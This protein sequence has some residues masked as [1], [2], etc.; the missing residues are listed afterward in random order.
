M[1]KTTMERYEAIKKKLRLAEHD[2]AWHV[3]SGYIPKESVLRRWRRLD[4]LE[5]ALFAKG[6][7]EIS[8]ETHK[9]REA[10]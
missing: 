9:D 8:A 4:A 10:A 5:D 6:C 1:K 7:E 2:I 3:A